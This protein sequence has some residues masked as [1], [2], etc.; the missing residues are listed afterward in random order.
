MVFFRLGVNKKK[1]QLIKL[2]ICIISNTVYVS[3]H[4]LSTST[5]GR[6]TTFPWAP[7][8]IYVKRSHTL[9]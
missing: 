3:L 7:K 9:A 6:N 5:R 1:R 8:I 4:Q 2:K